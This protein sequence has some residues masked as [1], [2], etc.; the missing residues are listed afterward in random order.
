IDKR[1]GADREHPTDSSVRSLKDSAVIAC[2]AQ[3]IGNGQTGN[4]RP[5]ND[6]LAILS[7]HGLQFGHCRPGTRWYHA[8]RARNTQYCSS[9]ASGSQQV[10]KLTTRNWIWH[11]KTLYSMSCGAWNTGRALNSNSRRGALFPAS[12]NH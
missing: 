8:Q 11:F 4:T 2:L 5:Q 3:L 6:H 12:E 9:A 10:K 1:A 7:I